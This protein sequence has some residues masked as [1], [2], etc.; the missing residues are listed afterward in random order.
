[1]KNFI[2]ILVFMALLASLVMGVALIVEG[3]IEKNNPTPPKTKIEL[4]QKLADDYM[5]LSLDADAVN[6]YPAF[7]SL[8][9]KAIY[10][11]NKVDSIKTDSINK[12]IRQ[13]ESQLK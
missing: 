2:T 13:A 11:R 4:Y 3:L 9:G 5:Q 6:N 10:W 7:D 1:M 8:F 12:E